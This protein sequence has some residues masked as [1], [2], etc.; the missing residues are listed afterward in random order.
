MAIEKIDYDLCNGCGICVNA[1]WADVI[2][3]DEKE[4]KAVIKY[5][6]DCV[7]CNSCE[8]DCPQRAIS[9]SPTNNAT[10]LTLWGIGV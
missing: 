6:D 5:P 2:R 10:P 9:V 3:M 1:C 8:N 7:V 4:K